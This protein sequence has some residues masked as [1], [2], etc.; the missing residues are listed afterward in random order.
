MRSFNKKHLLVK[1]NNYNTIAPLLQ[2]AIGI[3]A[4]NG[5]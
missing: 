5:G 3:F 1:Y 2:G 4:L